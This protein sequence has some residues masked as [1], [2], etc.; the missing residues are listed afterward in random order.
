MAT[1]NTICHAIKIIIRLTETLRTSLLTLPNS[2]YIISKYVELIA[3]PDK[4]AD[5]VANALF[6]KWLCRHGL[7]AEI[8]SDNGK[9]FC[10]Y[11]PWWLSWLERQSHGVSIPTQRSRV[12][13]RALSIFED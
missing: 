12:R 2:I 5:T 3:I 6:T 1:I 9:E 11:R 10:N 8:V 4:Q 7:P 13:I